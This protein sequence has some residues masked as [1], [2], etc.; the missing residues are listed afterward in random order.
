MSGESDPSSDEEMPLP[1][2]V[3]VSVEQDGEDSAFSVDMSEEL[4]FGL[5]MTEQFDTAGKSIGV[6]IAKKF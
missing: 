1:G 2:G 5:T 4:P 6:S 3:T